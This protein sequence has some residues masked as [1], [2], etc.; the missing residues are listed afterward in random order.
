MRSSYPLSSSENTAGVTV[1]QHLQYFDHQGKPYICALMKTQAMV[2]SNFIG[3]HCACAS[4]LC[5]M[6]GAG[7]G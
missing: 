5:F 1:C 4:F 6:P 7:V 3:C 2:G